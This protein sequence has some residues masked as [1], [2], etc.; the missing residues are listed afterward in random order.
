MGL[1]KAHHI[2]AIKHIH[3]AIM[4]LLEGYRTVERGGPPLTVADE[5]L[6]EFL[7]L[8]IPSHEDT[9]AVIQQKRIA[10]E[11][12]LSRRITKLDSY[13]H[14]LSDPIEAKIFNLLDE[15][16]TLYKEV[17]ESD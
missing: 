6:S 1:T 4:I 8:P 3:S 7:R 15:V 2:E 11:K 13:M 12:F 17:R 14:S 16:H 10:I 9:D 5:E